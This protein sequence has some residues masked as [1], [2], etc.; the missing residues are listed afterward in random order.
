MDSLNLFWI[1]L[2]P[3]ETS[4]QGDGD[5]STLRNEGE[6]NQAVG[7]DNENRQDTGDATTSSPS[8]FDQSTEAGDTAAAAANAEP[9][10][11][12][13]FRWLPIIIIIAAIA[14]LILI[15]IIVLIVRRKRAAD[16]YNATAT[17]ETAAT[18][19]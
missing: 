7:D 12:K 19:W 11:K 2:V 1:I 17:S 8:E 6:D 13:R 5:D 4:N 15:G 18:K 16:G 10:G 9:T 3:P 14:A